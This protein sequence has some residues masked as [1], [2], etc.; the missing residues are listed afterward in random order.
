MNIQTAL[1]LTTLS[2]FIC[3]MATAGESSFRVQSIEDGDTL[4]VEISGKAERIQLLGIDAPEDT[5]NPKLERDLQ[6]TG[7][8]KQTLLAIGEEATQHLATLVAPDQ[9]VK[10]AGELNKRDR[11]GRISVI[12]YSADGRSLN[13]AMVKQGYAILLGRF[14]LEAGF[15]DRLK[16]SGKE[17]ITNKQGLWKTHPAVVNAWSGFPPAPE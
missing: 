13:E 7:L 6:R 16:E 3:A 2:P 4:V 12:V 1:L 14:P 8:E 17:A 10:L 5:E 9:L 11:Y 15:K